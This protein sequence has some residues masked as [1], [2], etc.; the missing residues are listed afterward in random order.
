MSILLQCLLNSLQS[1]FVSNFN[2]PPCSSAF[3]L[4]RYTL[5]NLK[6]GKVDV[7][8]YPELAKK[9]YI[10]DTSFSRQLPTVIVFKNG[11]EFDRRPTYDTKGALQKFIFN[12]VTCDT[13]K[14]FKFSNYDSSRIIS[15]SNWTSTIFTTSART[16]QSRT[17]KRSGRR[18][19]KII[20]NACTVCSVFSQKEFLHN[21][22]FLCVRI[23][24]LV[25]S[26][27]EATMMPLVC[28]ATLAAMLDRQPTNSFCPVSTR[29]A[30]ALNYR[31]CDS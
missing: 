11:E 13:S 2:F 12:E 5:D 10:N 21:Y 4:I 3:N 1:K 23:P 9:Y 7:G 28:G 19:S 31:H 18:L 22:M 20:N 29:Q 26:T 27:A 24:C 25:L 6:F 16:T 8:R 30:E 14:L 15:K 17:K